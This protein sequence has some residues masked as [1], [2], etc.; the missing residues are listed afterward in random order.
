MGRGNSGTDLSRPIFSSL[1]TRISISRTSLAK[2]TQSRRYRLSILPASS[3]RST[4]PATNAYHRLSPDRHAQDTSRC[5]ARHRRLFIFGVLVSFSSTYTHVQ[6]SSLAIALS[7]SLPLLGSLGWLVVHWHVGA[8]C[9]RAK[10]M[11]R[12]CKLRRCMQRS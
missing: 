9:V 5:Q 7:F 1:S 6:T 4:S 12:L 3:T 10:R 11:I 2:C 8:M